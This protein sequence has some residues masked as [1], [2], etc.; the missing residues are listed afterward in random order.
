MLYPYLT[1]FQ[2]YFKLA[3]FSNRSFQAMASRINEFQ[4]YLQSR[5]T[6]TIKK[7][8]NKHLAEFAGDF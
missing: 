3:E 5:D 4:D 6:K 2:D 7:F 1:P 8:T